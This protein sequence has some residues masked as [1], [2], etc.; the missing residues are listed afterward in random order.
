VADARTPCL[1]GA[2][3][4]STRRRFAPEEPSLWILMPAARADARRT[5]AV[6][7]ITKDIKD[8]VTRR[9]PHPH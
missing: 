7:E 6:V 1:G 2:S 4:T 8:W 3:A 5:R 9:S